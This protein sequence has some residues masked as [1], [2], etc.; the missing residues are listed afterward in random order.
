LLGWLATLALGALAGPVLGEY[1]FHGWFPPLAGVLTPLL[2]GE[3]C[4]AAAKGRSVI[5]GA[6]TV[7]A[8]AGGL[9]LAGWFS[10]SRGLDPFPA[11]AWLAAAI[12]VVV[13][14]LRAGPWPGRRRRSA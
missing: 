10:S 9:L 7:V 1:E 11:M 2:L 12:A 4:V 6:V 5:S 13:G 3:V 14:W 8:S